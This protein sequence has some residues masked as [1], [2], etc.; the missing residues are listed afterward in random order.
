MAEEILFN[1]KCQR[2]STCNA[3]ETLLVDRSVA[4]AFIPKAAG[5][6]L[7]KNVEFHADAESLPLIQQGAG[8]APWWPVWRRGPILIRSTTT[9]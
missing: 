3:A 5:R 2:P 7:G 6:L 4:A 8:I 1:S 9:T